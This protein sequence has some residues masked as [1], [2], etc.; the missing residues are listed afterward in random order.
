MSK[1]LYHGSRDYDGNLDPA[2][3]RSGMGVSF[4]SN[5]KLARFYVHEKGYLFKA[6][7]DIR[8]PFNCTLDEYTK[9]STK[10]ERIWR[11]QLLAQGYDGLI[12]DNMGDKYHIP[13]HANQIKVISK[14]K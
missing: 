10:L 1:F 12:V 14:T 7:L 2:K 8:N 5:E 6:E 13:L 3:T 11:D 4:T 9:N